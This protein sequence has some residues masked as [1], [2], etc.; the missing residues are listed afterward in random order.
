M[1]I[2]QQSPETFAASHGY[3][4]PALWLFDRGE[5]QHIALALMITLPM[6]V[7]TSTRHTGAVVPA[8]PSWKTKAP[9]A[10]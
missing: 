1:V 6:N 5:Q 10:I 3:I 9:N 4:G 8:K 2:L 7:I